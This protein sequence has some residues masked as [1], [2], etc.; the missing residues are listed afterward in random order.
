MAGRK[1]I[2]SRGRGSKRVWVVGPSPGTHRV[3]GHNRKTKTGMVTVREHTATTAL[4]TTRS[5]GLKRYMAS[6]ALNRAKQIQAARQ[7]AFRGA[8]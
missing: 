2:L 1:T 4:R 8:Y 6:K 7:R 3:K 5:P